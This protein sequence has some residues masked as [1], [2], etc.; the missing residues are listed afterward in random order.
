MGSRY[1]RGEDDLAS[2][3]LGDVEIKFYIHSCFIVPFTREQ[4]QGY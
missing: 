2:S 1:E 3:V 4:V